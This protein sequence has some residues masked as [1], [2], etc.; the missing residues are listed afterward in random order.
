MHRFEIHIKREFNGDLEKSFFVPA[1]GL[2]NNPVLGIKNGQ[3]EITGERLARIFE[4]VIQ[5]VLSL[6]TAQLRATNRSVTAVLLA[7]GFGT[8]KYLMKRIEEVV[9]NVRVVQIED[10]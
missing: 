1:R 7:G 6:V 9:G 4:P 5:E 8:S 10:G 3:V 2:L